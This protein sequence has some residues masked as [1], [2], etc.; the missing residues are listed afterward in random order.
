MTYITAVSPSPPRDTTQDDFFASMRRGQQRLA[1]FTDWPK[2]DVSPVQLAEA[3]FFYTLESDRVQ[4]AFCRGVIRNWKRGEIPILEH[5][6]HY[7][8]CPF[9]LGYDVKNV[10]L[11]DDPIRG[12]KRLLPCYDVCGSG[13]EHQVDTVW[14]K[15]PE[16]A[17]GN[18]RE[19]TFKNWPQECPIRPPELVDVGFYY[20]GYKDYVR[21]FSCGGGLCD[22]E[23]GDA[24][25]SE[26]VRN[27]PSCP[28]VAKAPT[29]LPA[30][31]PA[32]NRATCK[33]CLDREVGMVFLPCGH[34]C[35]C[36]QCGPGLIICPL[37]RSVIESS[38]RA[39]LA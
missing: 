24:P 3:G 28:F 16:Y 30:A 20:L 35:S 37:C 5:A 17:S 23:V 22:W 21:C 14:P 9:I 4:C 26:H 19:A 38:M 13:V 31:A 18:R 15:Y 32:D 39:Y 36:T 2:V 8:S 11:E 27:Y 6:K 29:A 1:T 33:I 25:L 34:I 7:G 12:K 10:P